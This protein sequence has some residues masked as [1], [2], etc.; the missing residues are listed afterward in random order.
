[1][2]SNMKKLAFAMLMLCLTFVLPIC[3]N[4]A[5]TNR[6]QVKKSVNTFFQYARK[7]DIKRMNKCFGLKQKVF[8]DP[9]SFYKI[10]RPYTR[11]IQWKIQK[12]QVKGKKAT[13]RLRVD[14]E[15]LAESYFNYYMDTYESVRNGNDPPKAPVK[16]LIQKI[17]NEAAKNG[18][19]PVYCT[20]KLRLKKVNGRW[21][22]TEP[23]EK[24][25]NA[26]YCDM[27]YAS[28]EFIDVLTESL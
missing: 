19:E 20:M 12:I 3:A 10:L 18:S 22:I 16:H 27:I 21:K 2:K 24:L 6:E 1:M 23:T 15:S 5:S 11:K 17:R 26:V 7:L 14:F 25:I 4:A 13:V 9:E 8:T 28:Y